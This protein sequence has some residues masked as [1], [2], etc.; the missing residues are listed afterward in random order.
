VVLD[1]EKENEHW[2]FEGLDTCLY[3][4]CDFI[5]TVDFQGVTF[6]AHNAGNF[7][8]F[9]IMRYI[10]EKGTKIET[11]YRESTILHILVPLYD[12]SFK[13]SYLFIP[14]RLSNF[15]STF[16]FE[17]AKS[18][19][20]HLLPYSEYENYEGSYVDKKYYDYN[21]MKPSDREKFLVWYNHKVEEGEV[22]RY[23]YDLR[24]YCETDVVLLRKGCETLREL[25]LSSGY[26]DPFSEAITLT[27][28]CSIV[29][30]KCFLEKDTI[31]L[32]PQTGYTSPRAYSTRGIKWLE[33][34]AHKE[35]IHIRHARNDKEKYILGA[36]YVDG[37]STDGDVQTVYEYVGVSM[38]IM[39]Y[40]GHLKKKI[41][42]SRFFFLYDILV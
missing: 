29:F 38:S 13:D 34:K 33:Y 28:A 14:T 35:G 17:G 22:F 42:W 20:P 2:V 10:Y 16:G 26:T 41:I 9:D 23:K 27:H 4:F 40:Y 11:M 12:I 18:Y 15:P 19:F 36:Y 5:L 8:L 7:D 37:I 31:A 32:I 25:F 24:K 1:G 21:G 3:E 6:L 39:I 30:R